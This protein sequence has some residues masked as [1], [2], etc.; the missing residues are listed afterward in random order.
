MLLIFFLFSLPT[1]NLPDRS[2]PPS[3]N[4]ESS[5]NSPV[6]HNSNNSSSKFEFSQSS[7]SKQTLCEYYI[8]CE[9]CSESINTENVDT[10]KVCSI[11]LFNKMLILYS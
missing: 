11:L 8:P 6:H 1:N 2:R 3:Y 5:P 4:Q 10:H 7:S 9:Y